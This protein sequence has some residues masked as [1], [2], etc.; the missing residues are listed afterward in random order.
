MVALPQRSEDGSTPPSLP[1]SKSHSLRSGFSHIRHR[2]SCCRATRIQYRQRVRVEARREHDS[3]NTNS[4]SRR[5]CALQPKVARMRY[6]GYAANEPSTTRWLRPLRRRQEER[7]NRVAVENV[8]WL[9]TQ[10]SAFAQPWAL[11][12]NPFGIQTRPKREGI[13]LEKPSASFPGFDTALQ[14]Q[15]RGRLVSNVLLG[16]AVCAG[17]T[18]HW[19]VWLISLV[20]SRLSSALASGNLQEAH[21]RR[22]QTIFRLLLQRFGAM[23][24]K[25]AKGRQPSPATLWRVTVESWLRCQGLIVIRKN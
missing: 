13:S 3:V 10:G 22:H 12:R 2:P 8:G 23:I 7:H 18:R 4:Q 21:K 20:T 19:R 16:L 6:F 5:D 17:S 15:P 11:G 14:C 25:R 24:G 9:I 1:M